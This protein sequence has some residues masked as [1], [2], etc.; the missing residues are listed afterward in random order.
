MR[1]PGLNL[2][3]RRHVVKPVSGAWL[4]A[5]INNFASQCGQNLAKPSRAICLRRLHSLAA[6]NPRGLNRAGIWAGDLLA[7]SELPPFGSAKRA[8]IRD[9]WQELSRAVSFVQAELR[10]AI[11]GER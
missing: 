1:N 9:A 5:A 8:E 3:S 4:K 10:A 11:R 6:G 7:R 2:S